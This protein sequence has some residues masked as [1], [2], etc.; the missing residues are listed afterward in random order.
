MV[1]ISGLMDE[2]IK[3]N[4]KITTC[5]VLVYIH[6]QMEDSILENTKITINMGMEYINLLKDV[7]TSVIGRMVKDMVLEPML[8]IN[9]IKLCTNMAYG[10]M[11]S[12]S[13]GLKEMKQRKFNLEKLIIIHIFK[14]HKIKIYHQIVFS[15]NPKILIKKS[16][17]YKKDL[18]LI[19]LILSI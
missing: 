9:I 2:C 8:Y 17:K 15:I 4:G 11:V 10:K 1:C 6:G 16:K 7:S 3:D 13:N 12:K 18:I 19:Y 14:I 5:K